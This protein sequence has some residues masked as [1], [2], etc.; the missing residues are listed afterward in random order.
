MEFNNAV[1]ERSHKIPVVVDFWA[2]WCGPCQF[3]GPVIEELAGE[4]QGKWELIKL[5]TDENQEVSRAYK[6]NSIPAV[7]MFYK[8][9]VIAEFTGALPKHQ[10]EKWLDDHLPDKDKDYLKAMVQQYESGDTNGLLEKLSLF[11]EAHPEY[12]EARILLARMVVFEQPELALELTKDMKP[13]VL[14]A[15]LTQHIIEIIRLLGF[16]LH[17]EDPAAQLLAA[18]NGFIRDGKLDEGLDALVKAVAVNKSYEKDLPRLA[19]IGIFNVLGEKHELTLKYRKK[20]N[21][22]L[23]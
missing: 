2:P 3:L 9:E 13:D 18:S 5:N 4:G 12:T 10:I 6:I 8:G 11:V 21:M 20:F 17:D 23:Y 19:V 14:L 22:A 15:D 7:K 1:I 16:K